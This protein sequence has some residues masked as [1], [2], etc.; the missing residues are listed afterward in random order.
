M[1]DRSQEMVEELE[2]QN[3]PELCRF[4]V[5]GEIVVL[6]TP[7]SPFTRSPTIYTLADLQRAV[8]LGLLERR[9][10][11]NFSVEKSLR[12]EQ[13]YGLPITVASR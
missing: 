3:M 6:I 2:A 8:N 9:P 4:A 1:H 13:M 11:D 12:L 10:L 5:Q 7:G